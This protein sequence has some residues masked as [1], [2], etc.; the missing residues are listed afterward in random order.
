MSDFPAR[1][2][3]WKAPDEDGQLLI[4]PEPA[5]LLRET[6][7]NHRRLSAATDT[8]IQ[9]VPL[10]DLRR[11]QR[12]WIGHADDERFLIATGHQTE[13]YHPGV[14]AKD[15]LA[16]AVA[17]HLDADARHFAVDTDSPKHL[18]LR[19]PGGSMPLTDDSRLNTAEWAG[20]LDG[21]TPAHVDELTAAFKEARLGWDF[22]PSV[23]TF[24]ASLKRDAL[25]QPTLVNTVTK[26]VHELDWSLGLRHHAMTMSPV[27]SSEPYLVFAHHLCAGAERFA[28]QY[29][30]ALAAYRQG[31]HITAPGRPM[32]D[33]RASAD[34]VEAPFWLDDLSSGSRARLALRRVDGHWAMDADGRAPQAERLKGHRFAFDS[35]ADGFDAAS[36]LLAFLRAHNL[37]L[38]PRA[39]T[40]TMFFR[41]LLA[42]QFVHGIGGGRYDQ[43]TDRLIASHFDLDPPRFSVTTATMYFPGA[44][45]QKRVSLRPLLQ[46]GRRLR[47]GSFSREKRE[48]ATRIATLPRRSPQRRDLFF[49]M[50]AQ[51]AR[52]A[53][54]PAMRAWN[55]RLE[56][57]ARDQM[58]QSALFDRELF[59][60]IQP[61]ERLRELIARYH[62]AFDNA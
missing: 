26:C 42:D 51:L 19:W 32:P 53:E 59:Y 38:A 37:R 41:L 47:H 61:E 33:L 4:W 27:W 62:T 15:A 2:A 35:R 52:Q 20:L 6:R 36:Q 29:N 16:N 23:E 11:R 18:R 17:R 1:Y 39:L 44:R 40:L 54:S 7:D 31:Q 13:L 34:E 21:P 58:R 24:L 57:A 48:L 14:W 5:A 22:E 28:K 8:L 49:Q 46:E 25:E 3:D 12:Q 43:V 60:A 55:Q 56:E 50:H 30:D 9:N 45:G 10:V